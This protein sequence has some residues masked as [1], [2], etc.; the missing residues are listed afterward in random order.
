MRQKS[1]TNKLWQRRLTLVLA[2]LLCF[3]VASVEYVAEQEPVK[4][5]NHQSSDSG[6]FTVLSMAVDAVVPFAVQITQTALYFIYDIISFE[7]RTFVV[8]TVSVPQDNQLVQI[9]FERI[10]STQG[11]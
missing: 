2:M 10:I 5:E 11:P 9:L 3:F 4:V 6:D 8:S 7:P 1:N